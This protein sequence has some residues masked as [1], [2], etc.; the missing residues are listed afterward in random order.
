MKLELDTPDFET[1]RQYE[2][3][4]E[5]YL[6][7]VRFLTKNWSRIEDAIITRSTALL[8][9]K[10]YPIEIKVSINISEDRR[11]NTIYVH[12]VYTSETEAFVSKVAHNV[13]S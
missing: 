9:T 4:R 1:L 12:P 5:K 7:K 13:H 8:P 10:E 2:S 11:N 6:E 3:Y